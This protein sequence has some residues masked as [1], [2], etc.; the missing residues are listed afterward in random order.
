[1]MTLVECKTSVYAMV[2]T[3]TSEV[4]SVHV[5]DE[6][7]TP[8]PVVLDADSWQPVDVET[9]DTAMRTAENTIWPVWEFGW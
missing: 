3:E 6:G 2:D 7:L 4:V 1:M 5:V 9:A 8:E